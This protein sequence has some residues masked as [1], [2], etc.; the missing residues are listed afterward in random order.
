VNCFQPPPIIVL[1]GTY[2]ASFIIVTYTLIIS[3]YFFEL[4]TEN[5]VACGSGCGCVILG[6]EMVIHG[7]CTCLYVVLWADSLLLACF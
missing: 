4:S 1:N 2:I 3:I 7:C 6:K 5:Q